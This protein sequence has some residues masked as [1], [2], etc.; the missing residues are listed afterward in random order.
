MLKTH[1]SRPNTWRR[2]ATVLSNCRTSPSHYY[3][4]ARPIGS[5]RKEKEDSQHSLIRSPYGALIDDARK[6]T[7]GK[8][9]ERFAVALM[10]YMEQEKF[11]RGHVK[12]ITFALQQMDEF[13]LEKDLLTYN[14]LIDIFPKDRFKPRN[15]FDAFWP[16]PLPQIELALSILQKMEENGIRPDYTTYDLLI[17]IFGR[18]SFPVQKCFR[19]AYWFDKFKDADPYWI[20]GELPSAPFEVSRLGLLRIAGSDAVITE[21]KVWC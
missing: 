10:S 19:L 12:F 2:A 17:E 15:M 5:L 4:S 14:R 16:K 8:P 18:V 1:W 9:R 21:L 13:G 3:I 7:H 6:S 11:R 20:E